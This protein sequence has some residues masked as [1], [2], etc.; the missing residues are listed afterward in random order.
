MLKT[1]FC[2]RLE[3]DADRADRVA[4]IAEEEAK[5]FNHSSYYLFLRCSFSV[6]L[7]NI[8]L[9]W[10]LFSFTVNYYF[11]KILKPFTASTLILRLEA[12]IVDKEA[13]DAAMAREKEVLD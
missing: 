7:G 11:H 10:E 5:R 2:C 3:E 6:L 13:A 9:R 12:E 8:F 4:A 1:V